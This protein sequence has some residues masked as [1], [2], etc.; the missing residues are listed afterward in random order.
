MKGVD[1]TGYIDGQGNDQGRDPPQLQVGCHHGSLISP[2]HLLQATFDWSRARTMWGGAGFSA[3]LVAMALQAHAARILWLDGSIQPCE[4]NNIAVT[5]LADGN[6]YDVCIVSSDENSNRQ[7]RI[8]L[9][10]KRFEWRDGFFSQLAS[11]LDLRTSLL[12]QCEY[13]PAID[14]ALAVCSADRVACLAIT[15]CG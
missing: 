6:L 15:Q 2:L 13:V 5:N 11:T 8:T 3:L 10:F 14:N 4:I 7:C 12:V 9:Y 1:T